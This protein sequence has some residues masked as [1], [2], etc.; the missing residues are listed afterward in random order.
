MS[1]ESSR[2]NQ[3]EQRFRAEVSVSLKEVV[4][5]PQGLAIRDGLHMLGYAEVDR[6]R[7]GKYLR[8]WLS[9]PDEQ[10]AHQRVIAMCEKLLANPVIETYSVQLSAEA[11]SG[12]VESTASAAD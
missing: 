9:A 5:D 6:V 1:A 2:P 4:N 3:A 8:L 7:A 12:A 10:A 11:S